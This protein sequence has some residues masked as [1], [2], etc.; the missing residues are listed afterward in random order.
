MPEVVGS[1]SIESIKP[2]KDSRNGS[3]R[4]D[5]VLLRGRPR[6]FPEMVRLMELGVPGYVVNGDYLDEFYRAPK[7]ARQSFIEYEPPPS[8]IPEA[9]EVFYA[10]CAAVAEKFAHDYGLQVPAW[11]DEPK[12]FLKEPDIGGYREDQLPEQLVQSMYKESPIEF[13]RHNLFV[14]ANA[15][16][17]Y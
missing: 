14:T 7:E 2:S 6:N 16:V 1:S 9:D 15:L 8:D 13:S 5:E 4:L 12:Y 17:R 11:V 10:H 3:V